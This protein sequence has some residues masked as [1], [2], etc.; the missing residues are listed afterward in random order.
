MELARW[1]TLIA[2]R[3]RLGRLLDTMVPLSEDGTP[4]VNLSNEGIRGLNASM[5]REIARLRDELG[6]VMREREI[7]RILLPFVLHTDEMTLRRLTPVDQAT[8]PLLQE[9]IY[10]E[11]AGGEL[12]YEYIDDQSRKPDTPK[13]VFEVLYFCLSD[14]FLGR[15]AGEPQKIE[16]YRRKLVAQIPRPESPE[17]LPAATRSGGPRVAP[18]PLWYYVAT[19]G[20]LIALP[21]F[22]LALSNLLF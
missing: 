1:S 17:P 10:N 13:L 16:E 9:S 8:W 14:G 4:R 19:A 22:L 15:Y 12:F 3:R 2:A 21:F 20:A 6:E 5:H 7:D 11:T 18:F